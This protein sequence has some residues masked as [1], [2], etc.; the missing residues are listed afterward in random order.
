MDKVYH[1]TLYN[2]HSVTVGLRTKDNQPQR[3]RAVAV[4]CRISVLLGGH[5]VKGIPWVTSLLLWLWQDLIHGGAQEAWVQSQK[6][7]GGQ[8][9]IGNTWVPR[10][11]W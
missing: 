10:V 11:L 4:V 5:L 3:S 9:V 8:L 6:T 7:F 2:L 1:G